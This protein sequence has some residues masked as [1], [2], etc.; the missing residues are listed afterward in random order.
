MSGICDEL[1]P[2]IVPQLRRVDKP[3]LA[4]RRDSQ[5]S[6]IEIAVYSNSRPIEL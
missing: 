2:I 5:K 4:G 3:S 6:E 1:C